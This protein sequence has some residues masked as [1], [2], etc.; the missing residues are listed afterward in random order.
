MLSP[1]FHFSVYFNFLRAYPSFL[2]FAQEVSL[3]ISYVVLSSLGVSTYSLVFGGVTILSRLPLSVKAEFFVVCISSLAK[4]L[5]CAW[6]ADYL[7]TISSDI[8]EAAYDSLWYKHEINSQ[9]IMLYT[10]LRCQQ[11]VIITVPGLLSALTFQHYSSVRK[12]NVQ[13]FNFFNTLLI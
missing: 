8:A 1:M 4:V 11:P 3:S 12:H 10:L 13:C 2:L 9:K 7:M 5:L 6:P